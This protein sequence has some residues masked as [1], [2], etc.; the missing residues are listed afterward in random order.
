MVARH[1]PFDKAFERRG[2][3]ECWPWLRLKTKEGYGRYWDPDAEHVI[4]AHRFSYIRSK[5]AIPKGM[6][7]CHECDNPSCVNPAH[8]FLGTFRDNMNDMRSKKRH[9]V[10]KAPDNRGSRH[11][12][13]KLTEWDIFKIIQMRIRGHTLQ[14]IA[15]QFFSNSGQIANICNG[16]TW[17]HVTATVPLLIEECRKQSRRYRQRRLLLPPPT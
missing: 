13:S 12:M 6:H 15:D 10:P 4:G 5:G 17:K 2:E 3:K 16:K 14:E 7:V 8:L 9:F 11:G 1:V